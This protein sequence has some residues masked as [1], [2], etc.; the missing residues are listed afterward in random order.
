MENLLSD[1]N[2]DFKNYVTR[3]KSFLKDIPNEDNLLYTIDQNCWQYRMIIYSDGQNFERIKIKINNNPYELNVIPQGQPFFNYTDYFT[4]FPYVQK[5]D[6]I[7]IK[8]NLGRLMT[9]QIVMDCLI[10]KGS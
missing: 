2:I 8:N 10:K 5:S 9:V 6:I 4:G 3:T 1:F 7:E